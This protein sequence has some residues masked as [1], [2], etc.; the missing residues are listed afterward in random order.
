MLFKLLIQCYS[1]NLVDRIRLIGKGLLDLV[2]GLIGL[3]L[4]PLSVP[5]KISQDIEQIDWKKVK[6]LGWFNP[7][8]S[9]DKPIERCPACEG[10][11]YLNK[12]K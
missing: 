3:V 4:M 1:K 5:L 11:G 10:F 7:K 8:D 6:D 2:I 9:G 12:T